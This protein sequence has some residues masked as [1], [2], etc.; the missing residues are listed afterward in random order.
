MKDLHEIIERIVSFRDARDWKQFHGLKDI[1]LSLMLEA[2]EVGEI[3]Q[4]KSDAEVA[5]NLESLRERIGEE[6][7]DV[8][9][10]TLLMAHD[11]GV[12]LGAAFEQK[13][14]RNEAKY[15]VDKAKGSNKKYNDL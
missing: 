15:P 12:D 14:A 5:R 11:S 8:L 4:F 10:W 2:G 3:F 6:L 7:S 9:Y 13:M 1:A